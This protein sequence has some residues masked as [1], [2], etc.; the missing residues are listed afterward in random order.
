MSD[1][2]DAEPNDDNICNEIIDA[3]EDVVT[4]TCNY[5]NRNP[6]LR[7]RYVTIRR[8]DY[9]YERHL[10][11]LCEVEVLSCHPGRWGYNLN[12]SGPDC[13][14]ACDRCQDV[15]ETCRVL[16]GH[17]FTGCKDGYWGKYCDTPCHCADGDQCGQTDGLCP[18][19][20][21]ITG[22]SVEI[23]VLLHRFMYFVERA[24]KHYY[25]KFILSSLLQSVQLKA[26]KK[27]RRD[28]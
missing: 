22:C 13:S 21:H 8:K 2:E 10:L 17:C 24:Q 1:K 28:I 4:V 7:G 3:L 5:I 26:G 12:P 9:A 19:C 11:K 27:L 16:Y 25:N 18:G 6:P 20:D 15:N 23:N 14:N